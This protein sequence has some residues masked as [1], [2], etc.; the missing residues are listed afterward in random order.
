ML[1]RTSAS[2]DT[3]MPPW[4]TRSTLSCGVI[5]QLSSQH[6]PAAVDRQVDAGDL[7]RDVACK[8]QASVGDVL[9]NRDALQRIVRGVTLRGFFFRYA[10]LLGHVAADLVAEAR[11]VDHA[12]RDTIHVDIMLADFEREAL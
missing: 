8:K 10:E 5:V 6:R 4:M 7:A 1:A 3:R 9:V 11:A 12:G 2:G